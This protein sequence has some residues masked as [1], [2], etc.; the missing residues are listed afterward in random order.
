MHLPLLRRISALGVL[1]AGLALAG[2]FNPFSPRL[3]PTLGASIPAPKPT[4]APGVLR[5]FEWCYNNKAIAEYREIF[6]ADYQFF[7]SPRDSAGSEWRGVPFRREDELISAT[8]LFVGGS[9]GEPPASSIKLQLDPNFFVYPD[10]E[11]TYFPEP[12]RT[13]PRDPLGRWHKN[14]RTT[15]N[16]RIGTEDGSSIEILG[17]A[18]FYMVRGDSADIPDELKQRGF[19][20]DSTRWYIRRWDDETASEGGLLAAAPAREAGLA[21]NRWAA[22]GEG[23]RPAGPYGSQQPFLQASWGAVKAYYLRSSAIAAGAHP[24]RR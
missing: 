7:F 14:I 16:L 17:H 23:T 18:N 2:C 12:N 6:S 13:M 24:Q 19:G 4:S 1:L 21:G 8:Q 20:P 11:F 5:L 10:P 9:S 15:V 3:A 22:P